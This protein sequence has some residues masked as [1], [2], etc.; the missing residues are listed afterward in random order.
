M[1]QLAKDD[2]VLALVAEGE[3]FRLPNG[4]RVSP[5]YA[6]WQ[7][8]G[9]WRLVAAPPPPARTLAEHRAQA[10]ARLTDRRN[11]AMVAGLTLAGVAI[12]TDN[13]SQQRIS[14]AALAAVIDPDLTVTWK[15]ATG[16]FVTL[17]AAQ[18]LGIATAVRSHVQ[19]C[20]DR[21]AVLTAQIVA[22][23]VPE[24]VG[25]EAGWP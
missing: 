24:E 8:P 3:A 18:I 14:G 2:V 16:A 1:L 4:D 23:E 17:T 25:I 22:A 20:F 12:Q 7:H 21:E 13:L 11:Q 10:L 19:A 9:G 6:C 15:T 5:A